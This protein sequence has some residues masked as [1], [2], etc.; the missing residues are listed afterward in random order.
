MESLKKQLQ[1]L[2]DLDANQLLTHA[3]GR[4]EVKRTR[5]GHFRL[6]MHFD[7]GVKPETLKS[8]ADLLNGR[9]ITANP[10]SKGGTVQHITFVDDLEDAN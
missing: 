2:Q 3:A 1:L 10:F 9:G 6:Y 8:V 5:S 4:M 7:A